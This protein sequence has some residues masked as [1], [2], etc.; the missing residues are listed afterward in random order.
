MYHISKS[1]KSY[2]IKIKATIF[3]YDISIK[4]FEHG[5]VLVVYV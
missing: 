3:S 5:N 1:M 4:F 2:K